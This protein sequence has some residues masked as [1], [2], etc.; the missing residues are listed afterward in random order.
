V[1]CT[2]FFIGIDLLR[3]DLLRIDL[4]RI[5]LL[6]IDLLRI[7]LLRIDLLRIHIRR[8]Y[9]VFN[10]LLIK[11]TMSRKSNIITCVRHFIM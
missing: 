1:F 6:R 8:L 9:Q 7:D 11:H 10:I 4:L 3:I 5:D 2:Y